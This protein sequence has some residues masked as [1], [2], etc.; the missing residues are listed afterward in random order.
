M[1]YKPWVGNIQKTSNIGLKHEFEKC[2]FCW[3]M[4]HDFIKMRGAKTH[5]I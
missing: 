3:F 2:A 1:Q 4:L 5:E